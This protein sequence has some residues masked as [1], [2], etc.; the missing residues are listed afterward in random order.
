MAR[1]NGP[2]E[3][4]EEERGKLHSHSREYYLSIF[5]HFVLNISKE[6]VLTFRDQGVPE[7]G[8]GQGKQLI[9]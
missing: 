8:S 7:M 6:Y 1:R 3:E 5:S 2:K 9:V 4:V